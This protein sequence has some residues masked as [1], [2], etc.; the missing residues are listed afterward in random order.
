MNQIDLNPYD[1]YHR[2]LRYGLIGAIVVEL[3]CV[4]LIANGFGGYI[5]ASNIDSFQSTRPMRVFT[6]L[7]LACTTYY[8]YLS[9]WDHNKSALTQDPDPIRLLVTRF[10]VLM[11]MALICAALVLV[12]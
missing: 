5:V 1:R 7:V 3:V 4:A 10:L 2:W 9:Y 8:G 12:S 6:L 11:G